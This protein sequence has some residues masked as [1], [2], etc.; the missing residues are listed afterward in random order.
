TVE[1]TKTFTYDGWNVIRET[2]TGSSTSTEDYVWGLDLSGSLQGAVGIGGLLLWKK[3]TGTFLYLYDANGNVGQ[4]VNAATGAIAARYEYDPFGNLLVA[5]GPE[6]QNNPY[7]FSTKPYDAETGWS[8]YGGRYY[9]AKLGRWP[10]RDPIGEAGGLNLYGFVGNN[11]INFIDILGLI[12]VGI[13][14][15]NGNPSQNNLFKNIAETR[16]DKNRWK[17]VNTG[18]EILEF[19]AEQSDECQ[20]IEVLTI[21]GHGWDYHPE[22]PDGG[23]GIPGVGS[24]VGFYHPL[25]TSRNPGSATTGDLLGKIKSK[26]I[27]FD[28]SCSIQIH[29]C[30]VSQLFSKVLAYVSNCNVIAAAG[31][32]QEYVSG[33][34]WSS[35]PGYYDER[36]IYTGF[37]EMTPELS[38][39]AKELG[40]YYDPK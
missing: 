21:A 33:G 30:R 27:V 40:P 15:P 17:A 6:S 38:E 1:S 9:S 2:T 22:W 11:P 16:S 37:Y 26:E 32:C 12:K 34:T 8:Y 10:T 19:L 25:V 24:W 29:S 35:T 23:L 5:D 14:I 28:K 31:S 4:L 3:D 13:A 20:P 39:I 7:R 36:E 18:Q